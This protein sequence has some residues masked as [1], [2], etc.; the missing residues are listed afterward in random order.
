MRMAKKACSEEQIL[1]ALNQ[2]ESG[3]QS[4][5]TM[6]S[7]NCGLTRI[8][9][10]IKWLRQESARGVNIFIGSQGTH[11]LSLIDDLN[12]ANSEVEA[13]TGHRSQLLAN[14]ALR[15]CSAHRSSPGA[16]LGEG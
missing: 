7:E 1:L 9:S 6:L 8:R 11:W 13:I 5:R 4:G 3:S 12:A 14:F 15:D 10:A 16:V 2:A